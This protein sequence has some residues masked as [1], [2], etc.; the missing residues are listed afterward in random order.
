MI[1]YFSSLLWRGN[2]EKVDYYLI[3]GILDAA[4]KNLDIKLEYRPLEKECQEMHPLR[5]A[6]IYY[7]NEL[8][9]YIGAIHPKYAQINDLKDVYVAEVKLSKILN[10]ELETTIYKPISKVPSVERDI[11]LVMKKDINASDIVTTILSVDKKTLSDVKIFDLYVGD[12]VKEDEKSLAIKLVFT[13]YETLTDELVN[14]KVNKILK[15]LENKYQAVL[16]A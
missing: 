7:E 15:E 16:R 2:L 5:T 12:K 14:S 3:K 9:G 8:V 6:Q 10:K 4:L 1:I 11:A 13:S